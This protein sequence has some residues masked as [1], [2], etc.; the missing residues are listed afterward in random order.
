MTHR[1]GILIRIRRRLLTSPAAAVAFALAMAQTNAAWAAID[2]TVTV[3]ATQPGGGAYPP[4][5]A[6]ESVDVADDT[7]AL[8][9][10]KAHT[11]TKGPGNLNIAAEPG[12]TINYTYTVTNAGNVTVTNV[13]VID[14]HDFP[15]STSAL[16]GVAEPLT[17]TDNQPGGPSAG[18]SGDSSDATAA[19]G[20]WDILGPGDVAVFTGSHV[21]TTADLNANGGGVTSDG[22]ID[23]TATVSGDYDDGVTPV[24]VSDS[25]SDSVPLYLNPLLTITKVA[26][27]DTDVVAG[28]VITYTYTVSN[29]GNVDMTAI[30]LSDT[31]KGVIG[32]LTPAFQ[33]FAPDGLG[34]VA[35]GNTITV[36]KPGD[37]AVFEAQYTVT[38]DDVDNLQ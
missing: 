26:D 34:S 16:P 10:V 19:D 38:Q 7:P 4:P 28:Q 37:S 12:D 8:D 22:D 3:T 24:T 36:L 17:V 15:A 25:S 20:T 9:V 31:H 1:T 18:Q 6:T 21:V 33:N 11:L 14:Q 30:S 5:T 29:G 13:S 27:D 2:N 23:N 35:S 32:A